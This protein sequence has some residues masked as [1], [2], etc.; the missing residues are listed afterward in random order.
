LNLLVDTPVRSSRQSRI[1]KYP[2]P[3][4]PAEN[5]FGGPARPQPG[6]S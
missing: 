4:W 6:N 1:E 3:S 2:Q 5:H